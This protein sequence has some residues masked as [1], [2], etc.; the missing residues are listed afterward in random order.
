LSI[1]GNEFEELVKVMERLRAPNGCPWDRQ[2]T[3]SSLK[4]YLIEE[5][6]EFIDALD[7]EDD[8]KIREELGDILI[9]ILFHSQIAK[10]E[11]R[12]DI[13]DVVR[14][15]KEKLIKRH[16]HIF[17][18]RTAETARDVELIWEENKNKEREGEKP[19]ES[20]P[21]GMPA[22]LKAYRTGERMSGFGFDWKRADDVIEKVHEEM[23]EVLDAVNEGDKEK[24]ESE[25]G[26]LLFVIANLSRKL[27]IDPEEA[28]KRTI[29]RAIKRFSYIWQE[30]KNKGI[31]PSEEYIDEM[32]YLWQKSKNI[33][34][35]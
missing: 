27:M 32:E 33:T 2:Q 8:E 28:L 17:G 3:H 9:Q 25:I 29:E 22:L 6:Y 26:D 16:P 18:N 7:S 12:F 10:D 35:Y 24:I 11:R 21:K 13:G 34:G 4:R 14:R 23:N 30:F 15:V 5:V 20:L 19:L 31:R 1:L